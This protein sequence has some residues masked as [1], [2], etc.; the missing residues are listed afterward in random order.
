MTWDNAATG[1]LC[2]ILAFFGFV[3]LGA[4]VGLAVGLG[5]GAGVLGAYMAMVKERGL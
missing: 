3:V 2:W 5:L 4:G 1:L